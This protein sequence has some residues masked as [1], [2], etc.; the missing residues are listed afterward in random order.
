MTNTM[1]RY[2]KGLTIIELM[3]VVAITAILIGVVAPSVQTIN[4]R[5]QITSDIN[6]TSTALRFARFTAVDQL[7]EVIVCPSDDFSI[8]DTS[9]WNLAKI[10]FV[11]RNENGNRDANEALLHTAEKISESNHM[12]A[13]NRLIMF[14]PTGTANQATALTLCTRSK[15]PKMA[16]QISVNANGRV[17][18]SKDDNGDGVHEAEDG[19]A[20]T[21]A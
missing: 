19:S 9:N 15:D 12:T 6:S 20:L 17:K 14:S 8:C 5:S 16:R 18:L 21:C 10:V 2:Q 1:N 11:D 7:K 4:N 3:V 13:P